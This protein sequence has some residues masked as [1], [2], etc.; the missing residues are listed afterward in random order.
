MIKTPSKPGIEGNIFHLINT[1]TT[2][3]ELTLCLLVKYPK[4][5][6]QYQVQGKYILYQHP[7]TACTGN[8]NKYNETRKINERH[9]DWME[10]IKLSLFAVGMI[11]Y[12]ENPKGVTKEFLKLISSYHNIESTQK[13]TKLRYKSQ[14]LS[15]TL[16]MNTWN[17]K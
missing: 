8:S 15:Y 10:E 5:F 11:I 13:D 4:C 6:Y 12:V 17:W 16:A 7:F 1:N 2:N 3:L 14:L 9:T